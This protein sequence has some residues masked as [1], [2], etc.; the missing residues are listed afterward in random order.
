L[1]LGENNANADHVTYT[2]KL[3]KLVQHWRNF[4]YTRTNSSTDPNFHFGIVQVNI[5]LETFDI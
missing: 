5:F 1:I 4:W 3:I 2:C